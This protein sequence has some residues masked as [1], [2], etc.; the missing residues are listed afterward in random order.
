MSVMP[1]DYYR[2]TCWW[3]MIRGLNTKEAEHPMEGA[4]QEPSC[5]STSARTK[6][7]GNLFYRSGQTRNRP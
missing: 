5:R 7:N 6:S 2:E 4:P 3:I 1:G